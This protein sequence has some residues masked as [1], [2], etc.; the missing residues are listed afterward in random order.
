MRETLIRTFRARRALVASL[1]LL[2]SCCALEQREAR[3]AS[4]VRWRTSYSAA[5]KEAKASGKLL[6]VDLYTDWCGYC[7]KL[8]REV[9]PDAAVARLSQKFVP[10]KLNPEKD[11]DAS[12]LA[13]RYI[14]NG[15]PTILFLNAK[16]EIFHRIGGY[17]PAAPFAQMMQRALDVQADLPRL[18]AKSKAA[19][20][21]GAIAANLTMLY[22]VIGREAGA[23][24]ML[25]RS[26]KYARPADVDQAR[27]NVGMMYAQRDNVRA[28]LPIFT[29]LVGTAQ[30]TQIRNFARLSMGVCYLQL[31]RKTDGIRE[32]KAI[33]NSKDA[34]ADLKQR[35]QGILAQVTGNGGR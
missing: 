24:A 27:L 7:K 18:E 1:L 10:V 25:A 22:A 15:F 9:F 17:A 4:G 26:E 5:L 20:T 3:A 12:A 19:P 34:P 16:G 13:R 29:K 21:D 6:M 11:Q 23:K 33:G 31:G 35:A 2:L 8:D 30:T 14:V 32:L 28:A